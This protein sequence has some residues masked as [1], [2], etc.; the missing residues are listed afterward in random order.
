MTTT[1]DFRALCKELVDELQGYKVAHPMHCRALL[2]RA[3][4]ELATPPGPPKNCWLDDEPYLLP[5]PCVFDDPSE[6]ISDCTYAKTVKCK[7]DC[8][9]YRAATP[10][11]EP[12]TDE[13]LRKLWLDLY[14]TNDGPTSGEVATIA[15]AVLERWGQ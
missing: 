12:P 2:N 13:E 8:K 4:A 6:V 3:R 7:T 15:R 14:A 11:P 1:P 10:P 5:S 9:Y